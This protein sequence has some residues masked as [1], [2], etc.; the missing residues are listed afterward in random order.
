ML[1]CLTSYNEELQI[2]KSTTVYNEIKLNEVISSE[3]IIFFKI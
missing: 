2:V 1:S 3:E